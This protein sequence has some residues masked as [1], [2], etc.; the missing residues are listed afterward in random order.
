MICRSVDWSSS[1]AEW[2][3]SEFAF[4]EAYSPYHI[5]ASVRVRLQRVSATN[6]TNVHEFICNFGFVGV[7]CGLVRRAFYF[8]CFAQLWQARYVAR[9]GHKMPK[10]MICE[11][12]SDNMP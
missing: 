11:K 2:A 1:A 7:Y 4:S 10:G 6:G 9:M 12:N 3:K 5:M 8:T